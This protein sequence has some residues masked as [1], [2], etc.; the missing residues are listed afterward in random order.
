[1]DRLNLSIEAC[2][3]FAYYMRGLKFSHP[4]RK[5]VHSGAQKVP[6]RFH[7]GPTG[8]WGLL[9]NANPGFHPGLFSYSPYGRRINQKPAAYA[10]RQNV[11]S[12]AWTRRSTQQPAGRPALQVRDPSATFRSQKA[13]APSGCESLAICF[14]PCVAAKN[15]RGRKVVSRN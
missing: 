7:A 3:D 9:W 12:A 5:T 1:M 10:F 6:G 14:R 13:P 15:A 8:R 2:D 4:S 11:L